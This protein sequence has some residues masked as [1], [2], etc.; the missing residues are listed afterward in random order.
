MNPVLFLGESDNMTY[1]EDDLQ[2]TGARSGTGLSAG[3]GLLTL[4]CRRMVNLAVVRA[5]RS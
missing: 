4:F 1:L 2:H 3:Y 5:H